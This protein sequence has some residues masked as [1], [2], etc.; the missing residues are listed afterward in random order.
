VSGNPRSD[1][2]GRHG[3]LSRY[4]AN[5]RSLGRAVSR[6]IDG[7]LTTIDVPE[8]SAAREAGRPVPGCAPGHDSN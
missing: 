1:L 2:D 4:L 3:T 5:R 6:E 8:A 7:L